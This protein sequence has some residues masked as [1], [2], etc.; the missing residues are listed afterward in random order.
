MVPL[1]P[2]DEHPAS[3]SAL[4]EALGAFEREDAEE[5]LAMIEGLTE[6]EAGWLARTAR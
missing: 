5:I 1:P 4:A 2:K 6:E 3:P